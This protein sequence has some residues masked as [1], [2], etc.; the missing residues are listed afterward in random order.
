MIPTNK[1]NFCRLDTLLHDFS[2]QPPIS[3]KYYQE[4]KILFHYIIRQYLLSNWNLVLKHLSKPRQT[5]ILQAF[6]LVK[7]PN[8]IQYVNL[9]EGTSHNRDVSHPFPTTLNLDLLFLKHS[10]HLIPSKGRKYTGRR[11]GE[12]QLQQE[13][14]WYHR[15]MALLSTDV[16][17]RAETWK[18]SKV[19]SSAMASALN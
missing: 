8:K 18:G 16:I 13:D 2:P 15:T 4:R 9:E 3:F 6:F 7:Y 17:R 11:E 12:A 1:Y 14:E 19:S 5:V 10:M